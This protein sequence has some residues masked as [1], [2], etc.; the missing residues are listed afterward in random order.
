MSRSDQSGEFAYTATVAAAYEF[1]RRGERIWQLEQDHLERELQHA[2]RGARVLDIPVGTG[3][4]IPLYKNLGLHV[5]GVD[6]APAMLAEA[7]VKASSSDVTLAI[8][9]ASCI[10][11][12]DRSFDIVVCFRLLHLLPPEMLDQV[13]GELARV[14]SGCVYLQVYVRDKWYWPLRAIRLLSR[15]VARRTR[16]VAPWS[17]IRSY[18][19][20]ESAL[21]ESFARHGLSREAESLLCNYGALR[22]KVYR[23]RA[24]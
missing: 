6:I 11:A 22:V 7:R 14:S 20:P 24:P 17:H 23:L 21:I 19:H 13:I 8:G 18:E 16:S 15:L 4:F 1:D 5:L 2:Q 9:N 3:R 12:R 10:A